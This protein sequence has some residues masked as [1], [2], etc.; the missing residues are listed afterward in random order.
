[1]RVLHLSYSDLEGGAARAGFRIHHAVKQVGVESRFAVTK[2]CSNESEIITNC[3][4][5]EKIKNKFRRLIASGARQFLTTQNPVI[6]SPSII[7]SNLPKILN[8]IDV[9]LIHLHWFGFETLS[10]SDI[11]A[12]DKPIVWTLHD[13]WAFCGAEHYSSDDRWRR[14]YHKKNRILSEKGFDLNRWV[15]MRK[16]KI[17]KRKINIVTPSAWLAHCVRESALMHDWPTDVIPYHIN[18]FRWQPVSRTLARQ[19]FNLSQDANLI[20]FGAAGGV[21]DP[22][23]GFDL[24]QEALV[25]LKNNGKEFELVIFGQSQHIKQLGDCFKVHYAGNIVDEVAMSVLYS[26]ADVYVLPSRQ[27]NLPNTG[28]EAHSC[29]IPV[30]GFNVGG[31]PEIVDHMKTGYIAQPFDTKD[32]SNGILW[33][34]ENVNKDNNIRTAARS[35][36]LS[37]WSAEV[38]GNKYQELY[39]RV[40]GKT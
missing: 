36:A 8:K 6:H 13:M 24:L 14:G 26:A 35:R 39:R 40:T 11:A 10:I 32:L 20:L 30:V 2:A 37:E 7:N 4:F 3:F 38:V 5:F 34:L 27:D 1:M 31:V 16:K 9:D 12:I 22:R 17:W 33:V 25:S 15:W 29:G 23:K 21:T 18:P 19:M 28:L